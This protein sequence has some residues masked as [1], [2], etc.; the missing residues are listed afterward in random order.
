MK[1]GCLV[2][3]A[4]AKRPD[5]KYAD[6][7]YYGGLHCGNILEVLIRNKW[8]WA[9]IEYRQSIDADVWYL[10]GIENG[11]EILWLTVRK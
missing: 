7:T 10:P 5:I 3:D 6:G 1:E 8:Q 11:E 9:Q 2:W 4:N